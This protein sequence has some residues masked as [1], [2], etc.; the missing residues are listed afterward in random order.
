MNRPESEPNEIERRYVST[1]QVS[2]ALGVSVTTIKRWV[3]EKILPAHR[4]LGGHRKLLMTDV[5]RLVREG[6]LPKADLVQLM[7]KPDSGE[8]LRQLIAA[9]EAVD[10]EL[11]RNLILGAYQNGLSFETLADEVLAPA[12]RHIGHG[13]AN[14]EITVLQEHRV[15]Q[16]CVAALYQLQAIL[17]ENAEPN[18]PVALGG[19]PENDHY[20]MPTL[21][22]KLTLLDAGWD[23]INLG[24]HTPF[25][26]FES[27]VNKLK[28]VLVWISATNLV[29][30]DK[31]AEEY[32]EFYR[33]AEGKGVAVALGGSGLSESL[34]AGLPYT[35]FGDGLIHF[36][37]FA[38][39]LHKRAGV[40]KRGRPPGT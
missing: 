22:A 27:A 32:T 28:P 14:G 25:S 34:R 16:A 20:L 3:D 19:A 17:G 1:A 36:L 31:F 37:A 2:K 26:A 21:L 13:W 35:S 8:L 23:A 7:P 11:I 18:R 40:P 30:P 38:K 4:T 12:L 9:S 10:P 29:D 24:P 5:L 15:T 33:F 39:T 6:N